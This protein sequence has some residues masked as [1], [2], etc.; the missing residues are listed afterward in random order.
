MF[1][2]MWWPEARSLLLKNE[3]PG[4]NWLDVIVRGGRQLS[5]TGIGTRINV[6]SAGELGDA[7]SLIGCREIATGFGYASGQPAIAHFG[8][9]SVDVV[10]VQIVLPHGRGMLERK[11]VKPNER[12]EIEQ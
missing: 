7:K 9:G 2:P 1:L 11:G 5:S 4:G 8:L 6:Y 12:I 10:D 3:T